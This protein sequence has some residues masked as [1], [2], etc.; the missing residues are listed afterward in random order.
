MKTKRCESAE[1]CPVCFRYSMEVIS[2]TAKKK[3][4]VCEPCPVSFAAGEITEV[5]LPDRSDA[6][7]R[8]DPGCLK[9][10]ILPA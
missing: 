9:S 5:Y 1:D 4:G 2:A 6:S 10:V 3:W 8:R 7:A